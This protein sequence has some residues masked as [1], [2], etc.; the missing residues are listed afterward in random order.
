MLSYIGATIGEIPPYYISRTTR[1][2][3][4]ES[5]KGSHMTKSISSD[6]L[7]LESQQ[8]SALTRDALVGDLP[9]ELR[10]DISEYACLNRLKVQL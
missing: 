7:D 8:T 2:L 4:L 5:S 10:S 3:E 6:A 9:E 1:L